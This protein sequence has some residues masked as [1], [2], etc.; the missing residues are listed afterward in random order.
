MT[1]KGVGGSKTLYGEDCRT[2]IG[3]D[4][5]YGRMFTVS[6]NGEAKGLMTTAGPLWGGV[7]LTSKG[8]APMAGRSIL[9]ALGT[10]EYSDGSASGTVFTFTGRG[11]GHGVGMSQWGAF[12]MAEQGYDY[13]AILKHY[14]TGIEVD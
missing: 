9:S 2:V 5:L 3:A 7:V 10:T 8:T 12:G 13:A 1:L 4:K 6:G 11:Y 14:F